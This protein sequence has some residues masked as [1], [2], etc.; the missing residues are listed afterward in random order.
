MAP[1]TSSSSLYRICRR[2]AGGHARE[3]LD[4]GERAPARSSRGWISRTGDVRAQILR[5]TTAIDSLNTLW[6]IPTRFVAPRWA[7]SSIVFSKSLV[8]NGDYIM[9]PASSR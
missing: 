7:T 5:M 9:L 4:T 2:G 6:S 1:S 3:L 8:E